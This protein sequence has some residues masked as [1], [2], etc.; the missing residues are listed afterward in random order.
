MKMAGWTTEA[1]VLGLSL[2]AFAHVIASAMTRCAALLSQSPSP[3]KLAPEAPEPSARAG[4]E[5][6]VPTRLWTDDEL[7]DEEKRE[8]PDTRGADPWLVDTFGLE[9]DERQYLQE[10]LARETR[11]TPPN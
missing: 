3:S 6:P 2:V 9:E 5:A 7:A 8:R 1:L 4:Q 11:R 10:A